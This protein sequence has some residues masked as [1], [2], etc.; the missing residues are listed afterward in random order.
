MS[1]IADASDSNSVSSV[2]STSIPSGY[3]P[4]LQGIY[5]LTPSGIQTRLFD[6][7]DPLT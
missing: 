5:I 4:N 2:S 3:A 7:I 6:Y 1:R